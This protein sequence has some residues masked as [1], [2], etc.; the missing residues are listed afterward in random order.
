MVLKSG[1]GRVL[2]AAQ[3]YN[4]PRSFYVVCT[5][6]VAHVILPIKG[7]ADRDESFLCYV[8]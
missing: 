6:L 7:W 1:F 2:S 5:L 3:V 4:T 8:G